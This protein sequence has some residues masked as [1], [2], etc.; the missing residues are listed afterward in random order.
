[1]KGVSFSGRTPITT[2]ISI[3]KYLKLP[4]HAEL[5]RCGAFRRFILGS[6]RM[7]SCL[8]MGDDWYAR[9]YAQHTHT[10]DESHISPVHCTKKSP[11]VSD[12]DIRIFD[13]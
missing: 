10:S 5:R 4:R 6:W 1:M 9:T 13:A 3:P 12:T 11:A 7:R 8:A 2:Y